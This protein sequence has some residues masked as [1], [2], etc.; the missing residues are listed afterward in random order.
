MNILQINKYFYPRGGSEKIFF[1]T[2]AGLRAR[3]HTVAEFSVANSHNRPSQYAKYFASPVPEFG[4]GLAWR[5]QAKIFK[6]LFYSSEIAEKLR[7]LNTDFQPE[8]AHL[9]NVYHQL[10]ASTFTA[11]RRLRIPMVMTL[12][13]LFPLCPNHNLFYG[14]RPRE[15][16]FKNK[17]YNCVRYRC[18]V[19]KFLPSLAG[20]LEAYYYRYQKIWDSIERFICPS[21]FMKNKMVEYGFPD[22]K[23][24]VIKNPFALVG[25]PPPL[26]EKIV[27]LGRLHYEKGIRIFMEAVRVLRDYQTV[28]AGS[29]PEERWVNE[30]I[31]KNKLSNVEHRGWVTGQA[32]NEIME[33]A[34]V[35][36]VPSVALEN[37]SG[38][39]LEALS[40]GRLVVATNR[41]GNPE[42]I[43]DGITGFLARPEDPNDLARAVKAALAL[44]SD[45]AEK[46]IAAGRALIAKQ[47]NPEAYFNQLLSVYQA[48]AP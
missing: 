37:C 28:I 38:A 45:A 5:E 15:D 47:H 36:V 14:E 22:K 46:F 7:R 48:V 17:L 39:I 24:R 25:N 13:D 21:E 12:H 29:G 26:G 27:F 40:Y 32:W 2:I 3:G 31:Q 33:S 20:T 1:D 4:S 41:G 11:L 8:I 23:M 10:S 44:P 18:V 42:L 34:R 43:Q 6:R 16:L 19:N 9:H 35:I 30:F